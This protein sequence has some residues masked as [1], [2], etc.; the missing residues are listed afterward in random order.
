MRRNVPLVVLMIPLAAVGVTYGG[1]SPHLTLND[2][3]PVWDDPIVGMVPLFIVFAGY[4]GGVDLT[5]PVAWVAIAVATVLAWATGDITAGKIGDEADL[6]SGN[7]WTRFMAFALSDTTRA[8][9]G[10]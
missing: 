10:R 6:M 8:D 7:R 3:V 9:W 5:V 2:L 1:S 4:F